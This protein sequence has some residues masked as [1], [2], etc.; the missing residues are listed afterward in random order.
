MTCSLL[1]ALAAIDEAVNTFSHR[2]RIFGDSMS[3]D[4]RSVSNIDCAK[5]AIVA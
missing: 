5:G 2:R 4:L 3:T 1:R